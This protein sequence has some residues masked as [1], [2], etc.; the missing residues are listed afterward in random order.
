MR[1]VHGMRHSKLYNVWNSMRSRCENPNVATY[2]NYG[3]RGICVCD[4]WKEFANFY[5][6]MGEPKRG[7]TL[8]RIDNN[9]G[10]EP[11]NCVWVS[12][13]A[14]GRNKRNN[15]LITIDGEVHPL[16]YWVEKFGISYATAHQRIT[17]YGWPPE[18]AV[19]APL[20]IKRM[21]IARGRRI[22]PAM[23]SEA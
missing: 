5:A 13:T 20:T 4:R 21:G 15:V 16:S 18:I 19:S 11:E 17:K 23:R 2:E 6:D 7:Q 1:Y 9:R 3:G 14:Q 22:N 8:E 10:Y 12:R